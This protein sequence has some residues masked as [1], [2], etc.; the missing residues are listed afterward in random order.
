MTD[1]GLFSATEVKDTRISS[2]N[3]SPKQGSFLPP[4]SNIVTATTNQLNDT[5]FTV[6]SD[7]SNN[8]NPSSPKVDSEQNNV[9]NVIQNISD[10]IFK[11]SPHSNSASNISS[12]HSPALS[13]TS[14]SSPQ[15][16]LN[17]SKPNSRRTS[18]T[19]LSQNSRISTAKPRYHLPPKKLSYNQEFLLIPDSIKN[20]PYVARHIN[21]YPTTAS[22]IPRAAIKHEDYRS[23]SAPKLDE[24]TQKRLNNEEYDKNVSVDQLKSSSNQ[25]RLLER[26]CIDQC[27]YPQAKQA[28]I[29]YKK[30]LREITSKSNHLATKSNLDELLAKRNEL[31]AL[32]EFY[33]SEWNT[34]LKAYDETVE[35]RENELQKQFEDEL[36]YFI[37]E[38]PEGLPPLFQRNSKEYL[39]MRSKEKHLAITRQFDEAQKMKQK[40]DALHIIEQEKNQESKDAYYRKKEKRLI[41][42]Q[43]ATF[44]NFVELSDDKREQLQRKRNDQIE[45]ALTRVK[46]INKQ[47]EKICEEKGISQKDLDLNIVDEERVKLLQKTETSFP[48]PGFRMSA[49]ATR[50]SN[51]KKNETKN[52]NYQNDQDQ[53]D[54]SQNDQSQ[55]DQSQNDQNQNDQNE[56]DQNQNDQNQNDQD[57][58]QDD[59]IMN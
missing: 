9:E 47:I 18:Q 29:T 55:N 37:E 22:T 48:I 45:G 50:Q 24:Y 43:Q 2:N 28:M 25:L 21:R 56:N 27:Q 57:H 5:S 49:L 58:S 42:K 6:Q 7:N 8:S 44:N 40:A 46:L 20:N 10:G 53:N 19:S 14:Y 39:E 15:T 36:K 1:G 35:E 51:R 34:T 30:I 52:N 4:L 26:Y 59:I 23:L 32:V 54:Q 16:P 33:R 13:N 12:P 3:N 38:I 31:L 17:K 41:K 11:K